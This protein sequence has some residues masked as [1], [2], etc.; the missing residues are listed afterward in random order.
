MN[1]NSGSSDL[2]RGGRLLGL[3]GQWLCMS[4][5]F[6]GNYSSGNCAGFS[7]ASESRVWHRKVTILLRI[8]QI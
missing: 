1:Q 3:W 4:V 7:P 6:C 5:T 8:W 2:F